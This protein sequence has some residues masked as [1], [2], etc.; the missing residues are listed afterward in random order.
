MIPVSLGRDFA[1]EQ[2]R[3]MALDLA[4]NMMRAAIARSKRF[5]L[6]ISTKVCLYLLDEREIY[7]RNR[8]NFL[9]ASYYDDDQQQQQQQNALSKAGAGAVDRNLHPGKWIPENMA[10]YYLHEYGFLQQPFL[11]RLQ[12]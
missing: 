1:F 8:E 2:R 7:L 4:Q 3:L 9:P 6:L 11:V 12:T 10:K 5:N